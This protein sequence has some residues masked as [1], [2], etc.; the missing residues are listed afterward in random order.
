M[1]QVAFA[2]SLSKHSNQL[3]KLNISEFKNY[4]LHNGFELDR[5]FGLQMPI[6]SETDLKEV[7]KWRRINAIKNILRKFH[8]GHFESSF[9]VEPTEY[10]SPEAVNVRHEA[11]FE[12]YWQ[13]MKYFSTADEIRVLFEFKPALIGLNRQL[14]E[15][16]RNG[17]SVSIHIRRGD[18]ITNKINESIYYK[19]TFEYYRQAITLISKQETNLR[20]Y[21]FSDDIEWS[22]LLFSELENVTYVS[23]NRGKD[24]YVDMQLM[25][26]CKHNIIANSTFSWWG[27]WLN[28]N[29]DKI[30]V[31]PRE[32]FING[33]S[34]DDLIPASWLRI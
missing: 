6:A 18:F 5:I 25:S 15:E 2:Y 17:N 3:G 7:L 8:K 11:Y 24:S 9:I 29:P 23:H 31:S 34:S 26:L 4:K 14:S 16:V 32:W 28:R 22:K 12:G 10:F 21:V 13:S 1:F 33:R 19:C 20:F 27:A 30:V